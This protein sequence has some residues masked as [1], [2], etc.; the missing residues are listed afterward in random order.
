[1]LL[2]LFSHYQQLLLFVQ[3]LLYLSFKSE[4]CFTPF[5]ISPWMLPHLLLVISIPTTFHPLP[6]FIFFS[7]PDSTAN[8]QACFSFEVIAAQFPARLCSISQENLWQE[9]D[10]EFWGR[11]GHLHRRDVLEWNP[12]GGFHVLADADKGTGRHF[13][14][15]SLKQIACMC[16]FLTP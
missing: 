4:W 10:I 3:T 11:C 1:M 13:C 7:F 2:T 16:L 9:P 8:H 12:A 15:P 14:L 6:C 5:I